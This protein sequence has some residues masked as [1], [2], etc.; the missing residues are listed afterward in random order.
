VCHVQLS[1]STLLRGIGINCGLDGAAARTSE[2]GKLN[3]P[4][5]Q[6]RLQGGLRV[7]KG[8]IGW[9]PDCDSV[10]EISTVLCRDVQT[11]ST[12]LSSSPNEVEYDH[13]PTHNL[14]CVLICQRKCKPRALLLC[15][16]S[17]QIHIHSQMMGLFLIKKEYLVR[18]FKSLTC[19]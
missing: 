6:T 7:Q 10:L 2:R 16:I 3:L 15:R 14:Q 8:I 5:E 12:A 19:E 11:C 17:E 18:V 9:R 4:Q 1:C 13:N